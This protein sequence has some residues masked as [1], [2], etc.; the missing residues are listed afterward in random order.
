MHP[1]L[2]P[3]VLEGLATLQDPDEP[4][5]VKTLIDLFLVE[6]RERM[7]T[8][9]QATASGDAQARV[10]AAHSLK[11]SAGAIGAFQLQ[12]LCA[13]IEHGKGNVEEASAEF[14]RAAA[15]LREIAATR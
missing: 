5:I 8:I 7:D 9:Q 1:T 14:T 6:G 10:R 15:A 2:D 4:D 13:D 12:Q 11:G 3:G